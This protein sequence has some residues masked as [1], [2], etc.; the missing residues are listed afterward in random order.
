M[1][2]AASTLMTTAAATAATNNAAY[3][4]AIYTFNTGG[5]N[6]V[7]TLTSNL[8]TAGNAAA[9]I[10]VLEVYDNS[11]LTSSNCNNDTDTNFPSA[12]SAING[13]MPN[14]GTGAS[15]S[16]P[17]KISF[18]SAT[19]LRTTIA[20][21]A[22]NLSAAPAVRRRSTRR[23]VRQSKIAASESRCYTPPICRCRPTT[24]TTPGSRRF[25]ARSEPT[26]RA[27]PRRAC[28]LQLPPTATSRQ[29]CRH[30]SR[31]RSRVPG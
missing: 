24:G 3:R 18:W 13:I 1:A 6:T 30:C 9:G 14:P 22:R 4:M 2:T 27:A 11:C 23:G 5:V 8:T 10:D 21:R 26:C 19:A 29:R 7:Q 17:Q 28:I 12:M 16:T 25:R 15:N 31:K 20:V